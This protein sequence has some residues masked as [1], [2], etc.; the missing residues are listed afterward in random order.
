MTELRV[1][2]PQAKTVEVLLVDEDRTVDMQQ[3]GEWWHVRVQRPDT[4]Y[5]Y[6]VD[7]KDWSMPDPRSAHQPEG[8]HGPSQL[9]DHLSYKWNDSV[10]RGFH[11]PS[12]VLYELHIGTFTPD[13]TF[14]SAIDRLDYLVDLGVDAIEIMPPVEF[15]GSRGWGYDGVDLYAPHHAYGGPDG[16]KRL[17]D[18]C[19]QRGLGVIID[20]VYNHLGPDGN[21]LGA[22]GP[23]FTELHHTPWGPGVNYDAPGSEEVRKFV[24]DNTLMWLRDYHADGV[25]LDAVHA[26]FDNSAKHI[27]ESIAEEV[28]RLS[29]AL[30]RY[31]FVIAES[32][33]NDPRVVRSREA[34]GYGVDAQWSDDFHHALHAAL[35]GERD[36]YYVDFGGLEPLRLVLAN[37]FYH[38]GRFSEFRNQR[39]GRRADN[40]GASSFVVYTQNHDQVGNRAKGERLSELLELP[41]LKIAAAILLFSPFVPML[42]QGEEWAASSPFLYF[43][44]HQEEGLG[45]AVSEGRKKEFASFVWSPD[46][47]PDP[48]SPESFDASKLA[49]EERDHGMHADMLA[50]YKALIQLRRQWPVLRQGRD[51]AY[52]ATA[53]DSVLTV[54]RGQ[55]LLVVNIGA[56]A[57]EHPI[58]G[59]GRVL[60]AAPSDAVIANARLR[61][62]ADGVAIVQFG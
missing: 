29:L 45:K 28:W 31:K 43:T 25:R 42:F 26:L 49:W 22:F 38:D 3:E 58:D 17:I 20:V 56:E 48:Q 51:D 9:V 13:G 46:E 34:G 59:E 8:V 33:L 30:G 23:Y 62:P 54:R 32:D 5:K 44:D 16:L 50:W 37:N 21:Y 10:W 11:L 52:E 1:W 40:V 36:G 53:T 60:L 15:P 39:F 24:V 14:E 41:R 61:L 27:V 4:K 47:I 19:H 18:A 35:T 2:A 55:L 12:A 6:I 57:Y 7:G